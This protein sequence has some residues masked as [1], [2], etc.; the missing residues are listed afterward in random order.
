MM[1]N[2]AVAILPYGA[3]LGLFPGRTSLDLLNWPLGQ[4][5]RLLGK[6]LSDMRR[7]DHLIVYPSTTAHIRTGFGTKARVSIMIVEPKAVQGRHFNRLRWTHR[8]FHRVLSSQEDFLAQI[9]NGIFLPFGSTWIQNWRDVDTTKDANVS[10]IAS[11][12]KDLEGH[13]LRHEIVDW[14]ACEGIDL[15]VMGRGYKPFDLKSEGLARYRY[16]VIIENAREPNYF[17][18]KLVDSVLCET[19]PIYWGAPNIGRFFD[20]DGMVLCENSADIQNA[21]LHADKEGY[22]KRL[23]ALKNNKRLAVFWANLENRAAK[24]VLEAD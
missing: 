19:V 11:A 10:L 13:R 4:P 5:E 17:T 12:K 23:P 24:A 20:V 14:A 6:T 8:R 3:K 22:S 2:N 1:N 21:I 15:D 9:P 16:S 7:E 18:E